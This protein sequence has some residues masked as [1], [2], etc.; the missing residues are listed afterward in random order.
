[1]KKKDLKKEKVLVLCTHPERQGGVTNYCNS[2]FKYYDSTYFILERFTIGRRPG[3]K[4]NFHF[5][6]ITILDYIRFFIFLGKNDYALIHI[7]PSFSNVALPRDLFFLLIAKFYNKKVIVFM[8]GW[9]PNFEFLLDKNPVLFK[10]FSFFSNFADS[11]IVLAS[12]FKKKLREWGI[13]RDILVETTTFDDDLTRGFSLQRK[14]EQVNKTQ[15]FIILFLSR[16]DVKKGILEI[17][18]AFTKLEK[19]D[20]NVKL[21]IAGD[22]PDFELVKNH[23][24]KLNTKRIKLIGFVTGEE[25]R[26]VFENSQLLCLPTYYGEGLPVSILE[27]MAFGLPVLTRPVGGIPDHF[28]EGIHGYYVPSLESTPF[29]AQL[30]GIISD[31]KTLS[32]IATSNYKF[33]H[34][35]FPA[36]VVSKRLDRIYMKIAAKK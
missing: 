25:K 18:E 27:A 4:S 5:I 17:I 33:A 26:A 31:R 16:I 2:I 15:K 23:I 8:H 10:T 22:G 19:T 30:K 1:M 32:T 21:V 29:S 35:H 12:S 3:K 14:S 13:D 7:N 34:Q 6:L 24:L 28:K 9:S 11:F 36:S 20:D